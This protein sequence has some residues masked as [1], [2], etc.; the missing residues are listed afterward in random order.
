MGG[1]RLYE[2]PIQT[3]AIQVENH[4][5]SAAV[6]TAAGTLSPRPMSSRSSEEYG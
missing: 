4:S 6:Y 3:L 5:W 2:L 1:R